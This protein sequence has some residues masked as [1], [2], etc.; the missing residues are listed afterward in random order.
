VF[1]TAYVTSQNGTNL[2]LRDYDG[3]A[4]DVWTDN[5]GSSASAQAKADA[6]ACTN[7]YD[8]RQ[9][10]WQGVMDDAVNTNWPKSGPFQGLACTII[11]VDNGPFENWMVSSTGFDRYVELYNPQGGPGG[12]GGWESHWVF[13]FDDF[14]QGAGFRKIGISPAV[15]SSLA[16]AGKRYIISGDEA[17]GTPREVVQS[18][19]WDEIAQHSY[20]VTSFSLPS[21]CYVSPY[22]TGW[23]LQPDI[24]V[25]VYLPILSV[26]VGTFSGS[27][28]TV[29][30]DYASLASSSSGT[31]FRIFAPPGTERKGP[32]VTS[33]DAGLLSPWVSATSSRY[34]F[35][36][37]RYESPAAGRADPYGG[38]PIARQTGWNFTGLYYTL[39]RHYDP[40]LMRFT[41]IDPAAAP[42]YN[43]YAY[44]G[45]NPAGAYDPDGLERR[46]YGL[47]SLINDGLDIV[48]GVL[49]KTGTAAG[50]AAL[51]PGQLYDQANGGPDA[52]LLQG[53]NQLKDNYNKRL[54]MT[55]GGAGGHLYSG[56]FALGDVSG[57]TGVWE[58][59]FG[60]DSISGEELNWGERKARIKDGVSTFGSNLLMARMTGPIASLAGRGLR[61]AA[62]ALTRTGGA[63]LQ[64]TGRALAS[65]GGFA[66]RLAEGFVMAGRLG[67]SMAVVEPLSAFIINLYRAGKYAVMTAGKHHL[68]PKALGNLLPYGHKSLT[69]LSSIKHTVLQ[70][71]LNEHLQG[72]TKTLANGKVVNM[73]PR[74]GNPGK[75]VRVNFSLSER[76]GALDDFYSTFADGAY[77]PAF[78]ME[79]NAALRR[80]LK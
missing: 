26:N 34:L 58:G 21:W 15:S 48:E 9:G 70:G 77:H 4:A 23:T 60:R 38:P 3:R 54:E 45:G 10:Y 7:F 17:D 57:G 50:M 73:L 12:T 14:L 52:M 75:L 72:V 5:A 65:A 36:G 68:I 62:G 55:G 27:T 18:G 41:S 46:G 47:D 40:F 74:R 69:K 44:C 35:G 78:R 37:Y 1:A 39:H 76:M 59:A 2:Q 22:M 42:F 67:P 61:S 80:G 29:S 8:L 79:L 28:V 19:E 31:F 33:Q 6:K 30:G 66:S 32:Y 43:L 25:P 13:D 56:L 16:G 49:M 51:T 11:T 71:A 63:V 20:G 53:F 64:A 24:N